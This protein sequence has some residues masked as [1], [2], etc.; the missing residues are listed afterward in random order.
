[1]IAVG[2]GVAT[3]EAFVGNIQAADRL[4]WSAIGN[5]TNLAARLQAMTRALDAAMVI[6]AVT[7]GR[8]GEA[9]SGF[10]KHEAAKIAGRRKTEDIYALPLA[11]SQFM[12]DRLAVAP[13]PPQP[14]SLN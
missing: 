3:G 10:R 11:S 1:M 7:F 9:A 8:A 5:T 4:I 6:D 13:G 2:V 12:P 14:N